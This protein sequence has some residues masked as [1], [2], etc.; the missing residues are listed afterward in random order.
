MNPVHWHEGMFLRPH[1]FQAAQRYLADQ[2]HKNVQWDVNYSWGLRSIDIDPEA[3]KN[4][5][6]VV[7]RMQ[8]RLR[9]GTLIQLDDDADLAAF[10]LKPTLSTNNTVTMLLA[11]PKVQL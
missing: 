9:D 6:F 10:D 7:R 2:L 5:R 8:A 1:Q 3:L 11:V 4:Y